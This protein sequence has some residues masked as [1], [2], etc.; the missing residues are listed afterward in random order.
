MNTCVIDSAYLKPGMRLGR[1]VVSSKGQV[2]AASGTVLN[3]QT[4]NAILDAD[5]R[6]VAILD[7]PALKIPPEARLDDDLGGDVSAGG[8]ITPDNWMN[9]VR[10]L[11]TSCIREKTLDMGTVKTLYDSCSGMVNAKSPFFVLVA[12]DPNLNYIYH[13]T[14]NSTVLSMVITRAMGLPEP[15]VQDIF[16]G[17]LLHDVGMTQVSE[18]HWMNPKPLSDFFRSEV[19]KH[20]VLG[21][22]SIERIPGVKPLWV[23]CVQDH[24]ERLDGSGYPDKKTSAQICSAVRIVS[25]CDAYAAMIMPRLRR[26]A[27]TPDKAVKELIVHPEKFDRV[28][29]GR[30]VQHIGIYPVG[31]KVKLSDGRTAEVVEHRPSA[32]LRPIVQGITAGRVEKIDMAQVSGLAIAEILSTPFIQPAS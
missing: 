11:F 4:I 21:G 27:L 12:N 3:V 8:E 32:P 1:A 9:S 25:V 10:E 26:P 23:V 6:G 28:V 31:C 7:D 29:V 20:T 24:H 19:E 22:R 18:H 30:F 17:S 15:D 14:F 16:V 2:V 5:I 13:H